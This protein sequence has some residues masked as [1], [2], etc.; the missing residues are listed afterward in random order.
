M[1]VLR[2]VATRQSARSFSTEAGTAAG[3]KAEKYGMTFVA[4]GGI[5]VIVS[6]AINQFFN[7]N[8]SFADRHAAFVVRDRVAKGWLVE[9]KTAA[10]RVT[11]EAWRKEREGLSEIKDWLH[12]IASRRVEAVTTWVCVYVCVRQ[13]YKSTKS[14]LYERLLCPLVQVTERAS[15]YLVHVFYLVLPC[16]SNIFLSYLIVRCHVSFAKGSIRFS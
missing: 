7:T 12:L 5:G 13:F 10:F 6:L 1:N 9:D 8:E 15:T 3:G 4:Y 2:K 11:S 14:L 16:I